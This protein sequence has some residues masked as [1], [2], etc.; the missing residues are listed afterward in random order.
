MPEAIPG[1]GQGVAEELLT[2]LKKSGALDDGAGVLICVWPERATG[3]VTYGTGGASV[4]GFMVEGL[5]RVLEAGPPK[6]FL[7]ALVDAHLEVERG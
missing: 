7:D 1:I 5:V 6:A 2:K 3:G 4:D